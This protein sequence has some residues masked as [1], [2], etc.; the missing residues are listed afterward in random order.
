MRRSLEHADRAFVAL[1]AMP[2]L[3]LVW[4][5]AA[6]PPLA[7]GWLLVRRALEA[8]LPSDVGGALILLLWSCLFVLAWAW[9]LVG[10]VLLVQLAQAALW[11]ER[12]RPAARRLLERLPATAMAHAGRLVLC[13]MALVPLGA[14]LPLARLATAGW[15]LRTALGLP[16]R[17]PGTSP[18]PSLASVVVQAVGWCLLTLLAVN[19]AVLLG[20]LVHG[21]LLDAAT[22]LPRLTDPRLWAAAGL[23]ALS[24]VE[25]WRTLALLSALGLDRPRPELGGEQA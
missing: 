8:G 22:L 15:S 10:L 5:L 1:A 23:L 18:L 25:P 19:L 3:V 14:G 6:L 13:I 2:W 7:V 17:E 21:S 24:V 11:G 16:A 9:Y 12:A 4:W 20:W